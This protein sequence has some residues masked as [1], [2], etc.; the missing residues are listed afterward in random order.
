[1]TASDI[2]VHTLVDWV[3]QGDL[4]LPE[5]QRAY[6]WTAP[7]VRD[8]LDSLYRGYPSGVILVW[9]PGEDVDM[10]AA[11][12]ET[13][14]G[15]RA[16]PLL[17]LDGQQRLTSLAAVLT[18]Q[19]VTVR[20]RVK[21]IEILFNLDHPDELM[22]VT[23][24][25][26]QSDTDAENAADS[27]ETFMTRL[28]R[29]T[30]VV[31]AKFIEA[32]SNWVRVSDILAKKKSDAE[33][34]AKAGVT[35]LDDPNY[36]KYSTRLQAVRNIADYQYRVE[37]LEPSQSYQEVT[38]I[39]VRVNSLGAK[40]RS[41]D[42]ALAQITATWR[43]SLDKFTQYQ[44]TVA[45]HGFDLDL[46]IFLRTMV[47]LITDQSRFRSISSVGIDELRAGWDRTMKAFDHATN[48][49]VSAA[50]IDSPTLLSS[51]LLLVT[52]AYWSDHTGYQPSS[53]EADGFRRWLLLANAKG[54]YSR[55]SSETLLDQ[56]LV[57]IR[58]E[59]PIDALQNRLV[60]QVGR[61]DFASSDLEGRSVNSGA[62]KTMFLMYKDDGAR[63]WA[64]HLPISAKHSGKSDAIEF[65]H[66]YPQAMLKEER[67]DLVPTQINDIANMAF[68]GA[69]TNKHIG[70]R[71]PA[72]YK[73]DFEP[74]ALELQQVIIPDGSGHSSDFEQFITSRR[75]AIAERL[76]RFLE[77][78]GGD[79]P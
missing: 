7:R 71:P 74:Q 57:A 55:G 22:S 10:R 9:E 16:R 26:E 72:D 4:R 11:A 2:A 79:V 25:D 17:L 67:K 76:N 1:M 39:F 53:E 49:A 62:F 18:G 31:E 29:R 69:E 41:S 23:D 32:E 40:L 73:H 58:S 20:G 50:G 47:A 44:K 34:L 6:V 56:D 19:P 28:N 64:T 51:P 48:F 37:T 12:V 68:I 75:Q 33:L 15:L 54:R 70:K 65:H 63:D 35:R 61:L 45:S 46:G 3:T 38:E 24:V 5:M 52:A 21:P 42:L 27:E 66:I 13:G 43:G 8:L 14:T 30:F 36:T 78:T 59:N 77:A 60:Q